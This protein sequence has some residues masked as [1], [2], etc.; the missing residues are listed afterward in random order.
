MKQSPI[1]LLILGCVCISIVSAVT[2]TTWRDCTVA[3]R[4]EPFTYC[5]G[6]YPYPQCNHVTNECYCV[7]KDTTGCGATV[8]S[9]A[10]WYVT[11]HDLCSG[12]MLTWMDL[13]TDADAA[14]AFNNLHDVSLL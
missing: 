1:I 12:D 7:A 3:I 8:S 9:D 11:N 10:A 4:E 13:N 5:S 14:Y 6:A 2:C